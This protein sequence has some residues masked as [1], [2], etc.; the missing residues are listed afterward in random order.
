MQKSVNTCVTVKNGKTRVVYSKNLQNGCSYNWRADWAKFV[1][2]TYAQV[3]QAK[4]D[5][6][7]QTLTQPTQAVA[8]RRFKATPFINNSNMASVSCPVVKNV[9]NMKHVK[10]KVTR[11][12][13]VKTL[14]KTQKPRDVFHCETKNRFEFLPPSPEASDNCLNTV[15]D[16]V[17]GRSESRDHA[18]AHSTVNSGHIKPSTNLVPKPR[19]KTCENHSENITEDCQKH[20]KLCSENSAPD[21]KYDLALQTKN[22]NKIKMQQAKGDPTFDLWSQQTE[23]KFGY[24]P[25]GPLLLPTSDNKVKMGSDPIKLYDIM[26]DQ[27]TFNFL[28]TQIQV[29]SQL[30]PDLWQELL[31]GYWDKQLPFLIRYGFPLDFDRHSK[32]G[33]N[34]KNHA[35]ALAYPK[36]IEAYLA[37]EI[38]HGAIHGPFKDSPLDNLHTS[39]FMTREK[40][41]A[42]HRRV[43]IDLSFPHGE[44]VNSNIS[45]DHYLGTDFI[46]T[47]PSIDLITDKVRK[48]GKGS[49]LYKIDISRAF[50]HVKIDPRDYFL[51]GLR[52]QDYFLDTCLP[53]G[54]RHGSGIF[55]RLSDA[56]RF[57]M[58]SK[59]YD[60][61]NY[62]DDVIGFG[63]V[64]TAKASFDTLQDLLQKLGFQISLKK[65]VEPTTKVTCLGVDVDTKTFTISLPDEK[66]TNIITMCKKWSGKS[67]CTKKE[68]Q[69]LLGCLLY[70]S[71]CVKTSRTFL[72][73]MLDT[74]RAHFGKEN[75]ALDI[76]FHRDLNWFQKFLSKFNG[77]AFFVHRPVQATIELDACL[78]GL[79]AVYMNQVY[80]I[81]I[82]QY[83]K[84]FSIVHLEM[85]NILVAVRVW[86]KN[87][88][89]QRILIKCDN[90]AVVSVLNSGRTQDLTLAAIARNILMDIS[91][92]DID[93]QVVH[94]LGIHNKIADLLSR[95]YITQNPANMLKK[96]LKNPVWLHVPDHMANL[97]WSI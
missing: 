10:C 44:A 5:L 70:I 51:L 48:L 82:P 61:I 29:P 38:Q 23:E 77:T 75:I 95:W 69:S 56:I 90:Q 42:P 26:R 24:I 91:E 22:K 81:H 79:G 93:L 28:S 76:N 80:A 37:E 67:Q 45:K 14:F 62:I 17:P 58:R 21:D 12:T 85:L 97:D 40:P 11:T 13:G 87:W 18:K 88:K 89:N 86:G 84:N 54:F 74:L 83:C 27:N 55:Q 72:N 60:V 3:V 63:T 20:S 39:P 66:L 71:K 34:T 16:N 9:Q 65:L 2:K 96:L 6:Q 7:G 78:Q 46:L 49:L 73:R 59:G 52:H 92:N 33:K 32:L 1:G 43:I 47:L 94:I 19:Q 8:K 41:G 64:S 15:M 68:L 25:L 36:D 35:S 50:R 31:E 30:N 57:I 4:N 53:F